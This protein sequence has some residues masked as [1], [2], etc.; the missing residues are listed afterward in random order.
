MRQAVQAN[1]VDRSVV[2]VRLG[3][4]GRERRRVGGGWRRLGRGVGIGRRFGRGFRGRAFARRKSGMAIG[5]PTVA[6]FTQG[7]LNTRYRILMAK[8]HPDAGGSNSG[9]SELNRARNVIRKR[10]GWQS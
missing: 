2:R 4:V 9:A 8:A 7:Q 5:L 1:R 10:R 3:G 6:A